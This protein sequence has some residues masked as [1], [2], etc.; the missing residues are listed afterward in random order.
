MIRCR[1]S[2]GRR[3]VV[4][5]A[6]CFGVRRHCTSGRC[7]RATSP[8][9]PTPRLTPPSLGRASGLNGGFALGFAAGKE[10]GRIV[11]LDRRMGCGQCDTPEVPTVCGTAPDAERPGDEAVLRDELVAFLA[12][13][14]E[15]QVHA[16]L[17]S[18]SIE[19]LPGALLGRPVPA[20]DGQ[21]EPVDLGLVATLIGSTD[22]TNWADLPCSDL[23]VEQAVVA[24]SILHQRMR[25]QPAWSPARMDGGVR[26]RGAAALRSM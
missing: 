16:P 5:G 18:P 12:I 25:A 20:R 9:T 14:V 19:L 23:L 7:G 26:G 22:C 11:G 15:D 17:S 4:N 6:T 13:E 3:F 8:H 24:G 21:V 1:V 10:T 2:P